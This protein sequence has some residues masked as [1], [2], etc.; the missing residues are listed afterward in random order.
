MHG[1]NGDQGQRDTMSDTI[2]RVRRPKQ[3][4]ALSKKSGRNKSEEV[5][6]RQSHPACL[7]FLQPSSSKHPMAALAVNAERADRVLQHLDEERKAAAMRIRREVAAEFQ[8]SIEHKI[9]EMTVEQQEWYERQRAEDQQRWMALEQQWR[10]REA[11]VEA[12]RARLAGER[13]AALQSSAHASVAAAEDNARLVRERDALLSDHAVALEAGAAQADELRVECRRLRAQLSSLERELRQ[14]EHETRLKGME[15]EEAV[16]AMQSAV[17][18]LVPLRQEVAEQRAQMVEWS[19]AAAE[20]KA[21]QEEDRASFL[22]AKKTAARILRNK[23]MKALDVAVKQHKRE[24]AEVEGKRRDEAARVQ[25]DIDAKVAATRADFDGELQRQRREEEERRSE[26]QAT[27]QKQ[28][29]GEARA[30]QDQLQSDYEEQLKQER[31]AASAKLVQKHKRMEKESRQRMGIVREEAEQS[32]AKQLETYAREAAQKLADAQQRAD[33]A[34]AELGW[35]GRELVRVQAAG[36]GMP[37]ALNG[38]IRELTQGWEACEAR[39]TS[40]TTERDGWRTK[41]QAAEKE[42][43]QARGTEGCPPSLGM[44]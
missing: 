27:L 3:R 20:L 9:A 19:R 40:M 6:D 12:E 42:L 35:M 4:A 18:E 25:A 43:Q 36:E 14:T 8:Q 41:T 13:D 24:L 31:M 11:A 28:L 23:H 2:A 16:R 38:I 10:E 29:E 7:P 37:D 33:R 22:I 5:N 32:T 30:V 39:L 15:S 17:R 34:E 44:R 21:A 26:L 1:T